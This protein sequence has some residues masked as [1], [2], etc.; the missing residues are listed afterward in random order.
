MT[1]LFDSH[2]HLQDKRIASDSAAIIARARAK[3]VLKMMC[4][5]TCENDWE[6]VKMLSAQDGVVRP[7]SMVHFR[8][9]RLVA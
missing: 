2:C 9:Y 6:A 4:C 1:P 8:A 3:G 7:S 5:G